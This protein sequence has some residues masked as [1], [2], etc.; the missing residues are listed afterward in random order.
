MDTTTLEK[1]QQKR[2]RSGRGGQAAESLEGEG[3]RPEADAGKDCPGKRVHC[4]AA[5]EQLRAQCG[6]HV[7]VDLGES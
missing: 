6:N 2:Q 5:V 1:R 7:G 4:E 3:Y